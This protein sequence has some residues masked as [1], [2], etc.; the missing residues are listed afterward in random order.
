MNPSTFL[1]IRF[2]TGSSAG[3]TDTVTITIRTWKVF[4]VNR[5]TM[6]V[7]RTPDAQHIRSSDG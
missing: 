6:I 3:K 5:L 1:A 4:I 2:V 7:P